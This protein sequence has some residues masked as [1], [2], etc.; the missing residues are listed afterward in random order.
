MGLLVVNPNSV[1][2]RTITVEAMVLGAVMRTLDVELTAGGKGINVARVLRAFGVPATLL[3]AVGAEDSARY[4]RL[5]A[6]EGAAEARLIEIPGDVRIASIYLERE[7]PRVTV[8]NDSGDAVSAETWAGVHESA[9]AQVRSGDIV[10]CM[11]SFPTG[12]SADAVRDFVTAVGDVGGRILIDTAP[13]WLVGA[14]DGS[15]EV[16]TP[17]LHEAEAMFNSGSGLLLDAERWSYEETRDR[18]LASAQR[19]HE[20]GVTHAIVTAGAS[21]VA[22]S[23]VDGTRWHDAFETDAVSTVGAG[24]SF[25][26]GLAIEW[27]QHPQSIDWDDAVLFGIATAA[28]SCEQ[29]RAGG[30]DPARAHVIHNTLVDREAVRS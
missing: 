1:F 28:A 2:D 30:V 9:I 7:S 24:D 15:P 4:R 14:I 10:L 17:N 19:L 12:V 29:V 23:D 27:L 8:V 16:V 3:V 13:Q 21:G 22:L 5:L 26:A 11:G 20:R 25:V 18:A 6:A